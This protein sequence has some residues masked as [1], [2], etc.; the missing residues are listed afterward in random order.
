MD[1]EKLRA[2]DGTGPAALA[3]IT[4]DRS[5]AATLIEVDNVENWPDEFIVVTGT[6]DANGYLTP[7][8]MTQMIAHL[9]TG[10]III[11]SFVPGYTDIGNTEGQVAIIKQ[12]AHGQDSIVDL[13]QVAHNDDGMVKPAGIDESASGAIVGL[14]GAIHYYTYDGTDIFIDGVDQNNGD[15]TVDWTKPAGLKFIEVEVQGGGGAGGGAAATN[16]SEYAC[17]AGGGAGV[18]ARKKVLTAD[19]GATEVV[20]V[21]AAGAA[22]SGAAGGNGGNSSFG[23][24]CTANGGTGGT[25]EKAASS[26][27][28]YTPAAAPVSTGTGNLVVPGDAG[29]AG[30]FDPGNNNVALGGH[31]GSSRFGSGGQNVEANAVGAAAVGYG[32]GGGGA[33]HTS[34]QSAKVGGV[35]TAGI[36][37]VREYY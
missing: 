33:A 27:G 2:S 10:D 5:V 32:C 7:A 18:Y 13:L 21:G 25:T 15:N 23:A 1:L 26:A 14:L 31:G 37:I 28:R 17:G 4:A 9:D 34:S 22:A 36:I 6:L 16:G 11:D 3:N 35:G 20:T 29:Y 24:H 8:T 12:T 19:L 30:Q